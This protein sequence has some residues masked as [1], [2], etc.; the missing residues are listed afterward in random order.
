MISHIIVRLRAICGPRRH[1]V[2][3]YFFLN[4][5]MVTTTAVLLLILLPT[6]PENAQS[7]EPGA[8]TMAVAY[9]EDAA[10][11]RDRLRE[12]HPNLYRVN[13]QSDWE[14]AYP[15]PR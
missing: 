13:T 3:K 8:D 15:N 12:V 1:D 9:R 7:A 4:K 11:F 10:Y 5:P 2:K 14:S 6:P